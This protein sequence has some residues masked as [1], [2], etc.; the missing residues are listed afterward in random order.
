MIKANKIIAAFSLIVILSG[1]ECSAQ[2]KKQMTSQIITQQN[3]GYD[4][5]NLV[6][7]LPGFTN[8]Y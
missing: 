5:K 6:S 8:H 4:D 3:G 1:F 2:N 7:L